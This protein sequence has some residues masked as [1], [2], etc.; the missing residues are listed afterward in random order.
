MTY[1]SEKRE[2]RSGLYDLE[3]R[4]TPFFK[5]KDVEHLGTFQDGGLQFD[6]LMST[7]ELES[8]EMEDIKPR[9]NKLE[10]KTGATG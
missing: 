8:E 2:Y 7:G 3:Q 4:L 6:S 9:V 10:T 1:L 5:P